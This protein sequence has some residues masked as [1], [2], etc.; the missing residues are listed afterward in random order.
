MHQ[1]TFLFLLHSFLTSGQIDSNATLYTS[2]SA[3][4]E[5]LELY[6]QQ[7]NLINQPKDIWTT[8]SFGKTHIIRTG[9][10]T[11]PALLLIHGVN[12]C[13]PLAINEVPQLTDSFC[14]Y[15]VDVI[16]QPNL[17]SPNRP[18]SKSFEY[19][20]WLNQVIN[21]IPTD[22]LT[23]VGVSMGGFIT[24]N[25]LEQ[26]SKKINK[27]FLIVP[28]GIKNGNLFTLFNKA[29]LPMKRYQKHHKEEDL[30]KFLSASGSDFSPIIKSWMSAVVLNFKMDTSPIP[31]ISKKEAERIQT[32][33]Y[34]ISSKDDLF[35]PGE[36]VI[37][38]SKKIFPSLKGTKLILNSKHIPSKS[39]TELIED[40]IFKNTL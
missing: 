29:F 11:L 18:N 14:V 32:P 30:N 34:I 10:T 40:Y 26:P 27:A 25:A 2:V 21:N 8:T 12:A 13:A 20:K 39:D 1:L 5:I 35:F 36:K 22:S 38:R 17:S 33:L 19:G 16:G 24:L 37:K 3:Q 7:Y 23:L 28:G 6:Q 15:A 31:T 4:K 9:D